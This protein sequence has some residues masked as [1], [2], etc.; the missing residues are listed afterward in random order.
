MHINMN[1]IVA[2]LNAETSA[3]K[4]WGSLTSTEKKAYLSAHPGSKYAKQ[5]RSSD[6]SGDEQWHRTQA[7]FHKG[8]ADRHIESKNGDK[9]L[10]HWHDTMA[11]HHT[12]AADA[13]AA[14]RNI[15][16]GH[17]NKQDAWKNFLNANKQ[18]NKT[19]HGLEKNYDKQGL[20]TGHG[21]TIYQ[22]E[23]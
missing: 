5:V 3:D 10:A 20:K 14:Y 4:W 16:E 9:N 2:M 19:R 22:P 8:R 7:V 23:D 13:R 11:R 21:T 6:P 12:D 17:V 15:P 18:V 1:K